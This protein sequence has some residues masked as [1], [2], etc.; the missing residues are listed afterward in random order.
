MKQTKD[1]L[2][3]GEEED[4]KI[5]LS[6][7]KLTYKVLDKEYV[8]P[9]RS[10]YKVDIISQTIPKT[11]DV[12]ENGALCFYK[13]EEGL[14]TLSERVICEIKRRIRDE[15]LEIGFVIGKTTFANNN[16]HNCA[17]SIERKT[18]K[19]VFSVKKTRIF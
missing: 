4:K 13:T 16:A 12:I 3:F 6:Q 14:F 9:V 7:Y 15:T 17:Y 11:F 10:G 8:K 18:F 2:P 5:D 1:N 19:D